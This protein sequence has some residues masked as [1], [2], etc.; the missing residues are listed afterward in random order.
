MN[1]LAIDTATAT[2]GLSL[3]SGSESRTV[4]LQAGL[5]H[6]EKLMPTV[7]TLLQEAGLGGEELELIA[8][9]I[10]PGSFTGIRIGLATAKGLALGIQAGGTSCR[11]F[12]VSTLDGLAHRFRRFEG[13]VVAVNPSL[14][15][16][17]YA[18]VY[19]L[20]LVSDHDPLV[21]FTGE[22]QHGCCFIAASSFRIGCRTPHSRFVEMD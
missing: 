15:K 9:S 2:L 1:V 19:R 4:L 21:Y 13:T 16:K 17:H 22:Y 10:G 11:L 20:D 6:S 7:R 14:R 5:K 18:A 3:K 8:C 12:G